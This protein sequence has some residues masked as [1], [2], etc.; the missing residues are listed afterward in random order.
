MGGFFVDLHDLHRAAD[1]MQRV[2]GELA[3]T[4]ALRYPIL[5][6]SVGH[7]ELAEAL[8]DFGNGSRQAVSALRA[9]IEEAA[10]R[11]RLA[12]DEYHAVD[13]AIDDS[14]AGTGRTDTGPSAPNL[15]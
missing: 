6:R 11:A 12:L 5:L 2:G 3:D 4:P 13:T 1:A 15:S 14:F 10:N 8:S 9:R 7:P